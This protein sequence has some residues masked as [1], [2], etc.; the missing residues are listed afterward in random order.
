MG[1]LFFCNVDENGTI[2]DSL[3]GE[4]VIPMKQY[5]YFFYLTDSYEA[6]L[7][8]LPNYKVID[9]QLTLEGCLL[10][11]LFILSIGGKG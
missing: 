7:Q 6:V 2:Y 3:I 5:D 11:S 8:K 9:G 1:V 10:S 4:R